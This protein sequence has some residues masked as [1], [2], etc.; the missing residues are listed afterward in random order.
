MIEAICHEIG[1]AV[2]HEAFKYARNETRQFGPAPRPHAG[3]P[4]VTP[5]EQDRERAEN[6]SLT[7]GLTAEI[8]E[9]RVEQI[10]KAIAAALAESRADA[11][12]SLAAR[13]AECVALR[14]QPR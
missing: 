2:E 8:G 7:F 12:R 5:S 11:E 13:E 14:W 6:L 4:A 1:R 10:V 9:R 3:G